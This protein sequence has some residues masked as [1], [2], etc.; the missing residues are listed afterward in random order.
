MM[1]ESTPRKL[2]NNPLPNTKHDTRINTQKA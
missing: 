2:N 1:L